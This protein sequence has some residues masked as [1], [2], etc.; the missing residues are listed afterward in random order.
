[1]LFK[2][3]HFKNSAESNES[4]IR[5]K[6]FGDVVLPAFTFSKVKTLRKI[7]VTKIVKQCATCVALQDLNLHGL[8]PL[9]CSSTGISPYFPNL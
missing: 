4:L 3:V 7:E 5:Q 8:S 1:M 9:P 2:P 6:H